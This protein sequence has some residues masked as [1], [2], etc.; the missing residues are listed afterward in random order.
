MKIKSKE[1][2][3][4]ILDNLLYYGNKKLA[5]NEDELNKIG[6]KAII[7]LMPKASQIEHDSNKFSVLKKLQILLKIILKKTSL[8]MFI[9]SKV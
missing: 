5:L 2:Y 1:D 4:C 3:S 8:F 9:V 7:C 6:I